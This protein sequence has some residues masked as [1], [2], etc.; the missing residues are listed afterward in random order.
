MGTQL[1]TQPHT[2]TNNVV[3]GLPAGNPTVYGLTVYGDISASGNLYTGGFEC[4]KT[5]QGYTF[6]P[7]GVIMQWGNITVTN[8][9]GAA[10]AAGTYDIAY[11]IVFPNACLQVVI[12]TPNS[13]ATAAH[14]H[15]NSKTAATFNI[16]KG[17]NAT[18]AIV[19]FYA[20]G[21]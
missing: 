16:T 19:S 15:L 8:L 6:L 9:G 17:A 2:F 21:W 4:S 5:A 1:N 3:V 12:T 11:P 20:I 14:V 13:V 18:G 10:T 7:N